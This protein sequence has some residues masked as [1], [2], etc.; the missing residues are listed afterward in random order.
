[1]F[2]ADQIRICKKATFWQ[3]Q[4]EVFKSDN[5]I[6]VIITNK[7]MWLAVSILSIKSENDS[8]SIALNEGLY[9]NVLALSIIEYCQAGFSDLLSRIWIF[10]M[11]LKIWGHF[12]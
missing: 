4:C 9:V 5:F 10:E 2:T 6:V 12:H 3:E 7:S 1:M 11:E 8:Y